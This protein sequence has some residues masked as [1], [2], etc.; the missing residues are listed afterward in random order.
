MTKQVYLIQYKLNQNFYL[1][2]VANNKYIWVDIFE[3]NQYE[4]EA[5]AEVVTKRVKAGCLIIPV[6]I[7]K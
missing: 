3:A 2:E 5:L 1:K 6:E 7:T 4:T